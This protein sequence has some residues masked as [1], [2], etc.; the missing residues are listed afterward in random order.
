MFKVTS[1]SR[2]AYIQWLI[3]VCVCGWHFHWVSEIDFSIVA[4]TS[5]SFLPV[6]NPKALL[7]KFSEGL[8]LFY[9]YFLGNFTCD[10]LSSFHREFLHYRTL[11]DLASYYLLDFSYVSHP[12]LHSYIDKVASLVFEHVNSLSSNSS[13]INFFFFLLWMLF[14]QLYGWLTPLL[15][16]FAQ[17]SPFPWKLS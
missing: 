3:S 10:R 5:S 9:I 16:F 8:T 15:H 4:S 2:M 12:H 13:L 7:N 6:I 11:C 1:F 14:L 17:M